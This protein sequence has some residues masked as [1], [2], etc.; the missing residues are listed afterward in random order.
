MRKECKPSA[1]ASASGAS[2][3]EEEEEGGPLGAAGAAVAERQRGGDG[4]AGDGGGAEYACPVYRTAR[5][6]GDAAHPAI[7]MLHL[8]CASSAP[9]DRWVQRGVAGVCEPT[10]V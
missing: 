9:A 2:A 7:L 1:S 5:R 10:G 4:G 8:P 3:A 6:A